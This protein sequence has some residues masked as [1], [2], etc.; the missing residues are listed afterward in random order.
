VANKVVRVLRLR[1][2]EPEQLSFGGG[3]LLLSQQPLPPPL[4]QLAQ[5]IHHLAH[6]LLRLRWR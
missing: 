6:R 4:H 5:L 1:G 2:P 3:E